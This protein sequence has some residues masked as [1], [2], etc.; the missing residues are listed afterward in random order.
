MSP[1]CRTGW[2]TR[3]SQPPITETCVGRATPILFAVADV[4]PNVRDLARTRCRAASSHAPFEVAE[5][6]RDGLFGLGGA[7][8]GKTTF[9]VLK[10]PVR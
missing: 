6:G 4:L 5:Y 3:I 9:H 8:Q 1:A 2:S 10:V 7:I